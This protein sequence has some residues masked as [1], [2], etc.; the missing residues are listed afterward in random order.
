[1]LRHRWPRHALAAQAPATVHIWKRPGSVCL[2]SVCRLSVVCRVSVG[3]S[4]EAYQDYRAS[5]SRCVPSLEH[6]RP[7]IL[8]RVEVCARLVLFWWWCWWWC[9]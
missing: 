8:S 2:S 3:L 1:M 5:F 6:S 7:M 4:Q 9:C